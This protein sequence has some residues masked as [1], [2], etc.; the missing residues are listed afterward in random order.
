MRDQNPNKAT[1]DDIARATGL[2]K[3][4]VSRVLRNSSLVSEES[5]KRVLAATKRLNYHVDFIARQLRAKHTLQLGVVVPFQGLVGG[6]YFGQILQGIQQV[7]A[8]TDYH[9][10]LFDSHSEGFEDF[11]RCATLCHERRV[12]GLIVVAPGLNEKFP[13]T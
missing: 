11:Q 12:G 7:I 3:M 6:Y 1:M 4:T 9:I 5:R 8:G 10:A 13:K 2:S